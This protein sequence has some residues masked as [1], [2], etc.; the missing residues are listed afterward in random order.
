[1]SKICLCCGKELKYLDLYWHPACI[2]KMFS[3]NKIPNFNLDQE[4]IISENINDGNTI[5][6]V[7]KK[8]SL[9]LNLK[10][11]RKTI[12]NN[13]YIVKTPQDSLPNII[14]YEWIG[15]KLAKICGIDTVDCGIIRSNNEL[16]FITKRIDRINGKKIPM[17][18][19]CQ[20]SNTQTEYKYN[21]S[22]EK[23]IKNV[24]NKYSDYKTI[25]KIKFFRLILFSYIIGNTDMHLKNF[26][27]YEIDNK[28]QLS[29][30]YD[31]VPVLMVFKQ[32]EMALTLN[33]KSKNL[34]K[35][36]FLDFANNIEIEKR[37]ALGIMNEIYSKYDSMIQF[38]NK[39][40]LELDEKNKFIDLIK[41]RINK[42]A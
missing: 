19:F 13:E 9:D 32:E 17:E 34:T 3:T 18:D 30:A 33:G 16:L 26:S 5:T 36:D 1:M 27:L 28:Y 29:K 2:K 40:D 21:G 22:Y 39:T 25:D 20:L 8:F 24:I 15:M 37:I 31:L 41:N 11:V 42:F 12:S 10:K 14:L 7:Q 6:G 4:K 38:I 23:C 35:N